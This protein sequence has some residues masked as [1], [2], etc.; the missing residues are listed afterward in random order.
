MKLAATLLLA[1][2]TA[3]AASARQ[4][5]SLYEAQRALDE[6]RDSDAMALAAKAIVESPAYALR[7]HLI[8]LQSA[9]RRLKDREAADD[10]A[11]VEAVLA[12]DA[13]GA[14]TYK[15]AMLL[16]DWNR[17]R[18]RAPAEPEG[19]R[20]AAAERA[21]TWALA[22]AGDPVAH[23]L[24]YEWRARARTLGGDFDG[25]RADLAGARAIYDEKADRDGIARCLRRGAYNE[26]HA[27]DLARCVELL[28]AEE[29]T[30]K[31]A[32]PG[33]AVRELRTN[34][35]MR[36]LIAVRRDDLIGA[37]RAYRAEQKL[38]ESLYSALTLPEIGFVA[39][40]SA[41][42]SS[43]LCAHLV[44][45]AERRP[46]LEPQAFEFMARVHEVERLR[47]LRRALDP[48][49]NATGNLEVIPDLPDGLVELR[50]IELMDERRDTGSYALMARRGGEL[51]IVRLGERAGVEERIERFLAAWFT[52]AALTRPAA[53]FA[54]DSAELAT[55]VL[56]P[57]LDWLDPGDATRRA[58]LVIIADGPLERLPFEALLTRADRGAGGYAAL[59]FLVRRCAVL[60]LPSLSVLSVLP[61]PCAETRLLGVLDPAG[62][63]AAPLRFAEQ[64]RLGLE[65]AHRQQNRILS[66]PVAT[67][68]SLSRALAAEPFGWLHLACHARPDPDA[69]NR[70]ALELAAG[71]RLGAFEVAR[72]P[73]T[74]GIRVVLSACGTASGDFHRGEGV[75]GI[76][77]A[78]LF[79][80]ASCVV[81]TLRE[82][83][84]RSSA[85]FMTTFHRNAA[86]G[87][88]AAE[89]L[90]QAAVRW[91][92]GDGRPAYPRG[93]GVVDPCHP[94]LWACYTC[95]GDDGGV[96]QRR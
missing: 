36:T 22:A 72:L 27:G 2:V 51:R 20:T 88:P 49:T 50:Y 78:F 95:V 40:H 84:D 54:R 5:V 3:S 7:A 74:R 80:G 91:L 77:R 73:M 15:A 41:R 31:T 34:Q 28:D 1:L 81:S 25:A 69:A 18:A 6:G 76:W 45:L 10:A 61:R 70:A 79:A 24:A 62:A 89:A 42:S 75:L 48:L 14:L 64:E 30:L 23:A 57:V 38:E 82:V 85:A 92:D 12:S 26:F 46:D 13:A 67:L 16:G 59:P 86:N 60:H 65:A 52:P 87:L 94:Y 39:A 63:A 47:Q 55:C 83:D 29:K 8:R 4:S 66:G 96:L 35:F 53:D 9:V 68:D 32:K 43:I 44:D 33:E 71:E 90:Q 56:G 11:V 19:A 17:E 58:R 93:S 37:M 21:Y